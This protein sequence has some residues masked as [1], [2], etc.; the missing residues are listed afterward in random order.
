[1]ATSQESSGTS[2]IARATGKMRGAR[3]VAALLVAVLL[4]LMP[5]APGLASAIE[6]A[7]SLPGVPASVEVEAWLTL[8]LDGDYRWQSTKLEA[9]T[10]SIGT[11]QV[12]HG[13]LIATDNAVDVSDPSFGIHEVPAGGA[14]AM[15]EGQQLVVTA[16][17]GQA[18]LMFVE[19]VAPN[20]AFAN[21]KPDSA[22]EISVPKGR[23]TV[24]VLKVP[25]GPG[26]PNPATII[27]KAAAP[28][29]AVY[30]EG[31]GTATPGPAGG[32][33]FWLVALFP[34]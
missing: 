23:Y 8:D 2:R 24:A 28:A 12:H 22:K 18:R 15:G 14:L 16:P 10:T 33:S 9:G 17:A 13:F 21:E 5:S 20:G 25:T 3:P 32:G 4:A 26:A 30:P 6:S 34:A 27:A 31:A 7:P 29:I 1:M 11:I 19:L